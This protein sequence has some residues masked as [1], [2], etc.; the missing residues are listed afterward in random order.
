MVLGSKPCV[1]R[2]MPLWLPQQQM[3]LKRA[4]ACCAARR[5]HNHRPGNPRSPFEQTGQLHWS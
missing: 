4:I 1:A 3:V 2:G 5:A